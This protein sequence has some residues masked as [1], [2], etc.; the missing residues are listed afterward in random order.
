[1][2]V[3]CTL[4]FLKK[5]HWWVNERTILALADCRNIHDYMVNFK[6]LYILWQK[7]YKPALSIFRWVQV[8]P[9]ILS[10]S[11]LCLFI[12]HQEEPCMRVW[13][14]QTPCPSP[15]HTCL[16]ILAALTPNI[17]PLVIPVAKGWVYCCH[18]LHLGGRP[19]KRSL[20]ALEEGSGTL[21]RKQ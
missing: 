6:A 2:R 20:L 11:H 12:L 5:I 21:G 16:Q 9:P 1:M 10:S 7:L 4:G 13:I 8:V 17:C 3:Q 14:L 15:L 19:G 18:G